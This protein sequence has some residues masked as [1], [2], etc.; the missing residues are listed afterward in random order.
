MEALHKVLSL[1]AVGSKRFLTT[2][3]DR[4]VTGSQSFTSRFSGGRD[5]IIVV[6][7]SQLP[8]SC[9]VDATEISGIYSKVA[10]VWGCTANACLQLEILCRSWALLMHQQSA[11]K[12]ALHVAL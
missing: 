12:L 9:K 4:C 6:W 5:L 11:G 1:P 10:G 8:D 7:A 3:A 2:K